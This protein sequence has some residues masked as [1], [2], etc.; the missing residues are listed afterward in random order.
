MGCCRLNN[1]WLEYVRCGCIKTYAFTG[2]R[3]LRRESERKLSRISTRNAL[4]N[5]ISVNSTLYSNLG[6]MY[7]TSAHQNGCSMTL[8]MQSVQYKVEMKQATV[9]QSEW[10][11]TCTVIITSQEVKMSWTDQYQIRYITVRSL[12]DRSQSE[13]KILSWILLTKNSARIFLYSNGLYIVTTI[14][15]KSNFPR[16]LSI[17]RASVYSVRALFYSVTVMDVL[18]KDNVSLFSTTASIAKWNCS[19]VHKFKLNSFVK[20]SAQTPFLEKTSI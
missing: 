4:K 6:A 11:V 7:T 8:D 5:S 14:V 18:A 19:W 16:L 17:V 10:T 12:L 2:S 13:G 15:I 1:D 3:C 9:Y 20:K